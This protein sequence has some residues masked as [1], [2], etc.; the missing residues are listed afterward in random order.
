MKL[1]KSD[2]N[3]KLVLNCVHEVVPTSGGCSEMIDFERDTKSKRDGV[4][5]KLSK[6]KLSNAIINGDQ[7][8]IPDWFRCLCNQSIRN[9]FLDP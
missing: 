8:V 4:Q 2:L 9:I 3:A 6:M 1:I 5:C 7:S